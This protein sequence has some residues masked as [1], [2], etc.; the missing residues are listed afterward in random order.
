MG[1]RA[2]FWEGLATM[3]QAGIPLRQT[4]AH[5][6]ASPPR[7]FSGPVAAMK[8]AVD[9][10]RPLADGMEAVSAEFARFEIEVVRAAE[11]SG[12]LDRAA[13]LLADAAESAERSRR[14]VIG[15]LLYPSAV[16]LFVPVP[17]NVHHLVQGRPLAFLG[18]CL[19][20]AS[21]LLALAAGGLLLLRAARHGKG[22]ARLL[23][24]LPL[25]GGILRD[26]ALVRWAQA[27]AALDDAGVAADVAASRAAAA[28]GI[29]AL[30][31]PLA[32]PAAA[33]RVGRSRREAFAAAPLPP[34]L[35]AALVQ[36]ET[37]GTLA[38]SLRRAAGGLEARLRTRVDAAIALL[39][40]AAT[41]LAGA[42]VLWVALKIVGGYY[43]QI[44]K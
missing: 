1:A 40:V 37:S 3:L 22:A 17:L 31:E 32:A 26:A 44:P 34:D 21:P 8:A 41:I 2:R 11:A 35:L 6:D 7:G 16:L 27:Y 18:G 9:A 33:L 36:G 19:L 4:L 25:A 28:C 38:E 14:R 5:I 30:E 20:Y 43:S 13:R 42:A 12:T 15:A 23:L 24:A 10:G 29:A 39:P